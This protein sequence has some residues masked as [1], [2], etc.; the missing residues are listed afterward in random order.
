V[1]IKTGLYQN[2]AQHSAKNDCEVWWYWLGGIAKFSEAGSKD[3]D[4][5]K[6]L[7][8]VHTRRQM[9]I[10]LAHSYT[11]YKNTIQSMQ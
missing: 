5:C 6:M 7:G 2:I 10:G 1:T 4:T 9:P 11:R 3:L 8:G